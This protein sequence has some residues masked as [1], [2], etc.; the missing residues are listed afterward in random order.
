MQRITGSKKMSKAEIPILGKHVFLM[1]VVGLEEVPNAESNEN[2]IFKF[3]DGQYV[4]C[5]VPCYTC[6]D[7]PDVTFTFSTLEEIGSKVF[8]I[9]ANSTEGQLMKK[10]LDDICGQLKVQAVEIAGGVVL[11]SYDLQ[12]WA[13][14]GKTYEEITNMANAG[15]HDCRTALSAVTMGAPTVLAKAIEA[16]TETYNKINYKD[17]AIQIAE[18]VKTATIIGDD[19]N[20][21]HL[22]VN[23]VDALTKSVKDNLSIV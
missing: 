4:P 18:I 8:G 7:N 6:D 22:S 20:A 16:G 5:V 23:E 13:K 1:Q 11:T 19:G 9:P 12:G 3:S 2:T 17:K 10:F 21:R 14:E 15:D